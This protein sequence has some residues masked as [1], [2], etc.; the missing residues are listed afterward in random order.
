MC[1]S[2][3][4][5]SIISNDYFDTNLAERNAV[6]KKK[7]KEQKIEQ[8]FT[9]RP[10]AC[11]VVSGCRRESRPTKC[12]QVRDASDIPPSPSPFPTLFF[13]NVPS[14]VSSRVDHRSCLSC[15]STRMLPI[16]SSVSLHRPLLLL[17]LLLFLLL[18]L[19]PQKQIDFVLD[20]Y[21]FLL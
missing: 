21:F 17:L 2:P 7:K 3:F 6:V 4:L 13:S 8:R 11:R 10:T 12:A 5:P 9:E 1:V 19:L 15:H 20:R 16:P 14:S 18:L